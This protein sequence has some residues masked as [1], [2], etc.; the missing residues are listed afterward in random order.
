MRKLQAITLAISLTGIFFVMRSGAF[1]DEYSDGWIPLREDV[2]INVQSIAY[3]SIDRVSL[4]VKVVPDSE[5]ALLVEAR[6][7]L[8]A[9]GRYEQ[10]LSYD[11]LA[12][13]LK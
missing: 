1:A 12:S 5:S 9:K 4:W 8:M 13:Y 2:Y 10:E 6:N 7:L 3:P 11:Y